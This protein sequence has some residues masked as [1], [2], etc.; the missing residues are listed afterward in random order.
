MSTL[1][2]FVGGGDSYL[3]EYIPQYAAEKPLGFT[4][5]SKEYLRTGV[6]KDYSATYADI[7]STKILSSINTPQR[8]LHSSWQFPNYGG[9]WNYAGSFAYPKMFTHGT[10]V[11]SGLSYKHI[12]Y[13]GGHYSGYAYPQHIYGL[14]YANQNSGTSGSD[15]GQIYTADRINSRLIVAAISGSHDAATSAA[16]NPFGFIVTN[17]NSPTF[18]GTFLTYMTYQNALWGAENAQGKQL[19]VHED[20]ANTNHGESI[21]YTDNATS[22]TK[23][24]PTI[25]ARYMRRL[26]WSQM[27]N[28]F[29]WVKNN[30]VVYTTTDGSSFS[31]IGSVN[32]TGANAGVV[33]NTIGDYPNGQ[34]CVDHPT[35][36]TMIMLGG[37]PANTYGVTTAG[38]Y[39]LKTTNGTSFTIENL[40][41]NNPILLGFLTGSF[42]T[43]RLFWTGT[44]LIMHTQNLSGGDYFFYSTDWGATW[45]QDRRIHNLL[46]GRTGFRGFAT[47]DNTLYGLM[48]GRASYGDD[49]GELFNFQGRRFGA[50]PQYIGQTGAL[51]WT[52][53]FT[54]YERIK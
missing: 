24:T 30:G 13:I 35:N 14:N 25:D 19:W 28:R 32:I 41:A 2:Q 38:V 26:T 43:P 7:A 21:Y 22:I 29:I 31:Q 49:T 51:N 48:C 34:Y 16:G 10:D 36:G 45:T 37:Y 54:T 27:G 9:H 20:Y 18:N 47:M 39:V 42:N 11:S 6:L 23:R 1:S 5:G 4:V 40:A 15:W 17:A 8:F 12:L 44:H 46:D 53:S 33:P 52:G 50:T 3:G